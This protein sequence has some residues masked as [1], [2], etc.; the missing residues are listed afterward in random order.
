M[1]SYPAWGAP[2][3]AKGLLYVRG[4]HE[5]ICYEMDDAKVSDRQKPN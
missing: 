2:V 3:I 1:P 4:K 5:I